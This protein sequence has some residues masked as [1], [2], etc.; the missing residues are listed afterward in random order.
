M[1]LHRVHALHDCREILIQR[2]HLPVLRCALIFSH[3]KATLVLSNKLS[4]KLLLPSERQPLHCFV[5]LN[6]LCIWHGASDF[7]ELLLKLFTMLQG[8][9]D[10]LFLSLLIVLLLLVNTHAL[11]DGLDLWLNLLHP[12]VRCHKFCGLKR[13]SDLVLLQVFKRIF[14][15]HHIFLLR[16]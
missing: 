8:L 9:R 14:D 6:L 7:I 4:Y 10:D 13:L 12:L 16:G 15:R 5:Q 2:Y 1:L 11:N 3:V